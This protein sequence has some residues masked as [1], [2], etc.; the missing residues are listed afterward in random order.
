MIK[1]NGK[2]LVGK[3]GYALAPQKLVDEKQK[4]RFMYRENPDNRSDSGWRFFGGD[5]TD[6][7]VN[8]PDNI[9]PYDVNTIA[10]ID[11]DIIP[12]VDSPV[13]SAFERNDPKDPFKPSK[14]FNVACREFPHF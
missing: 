11:P 8:N 1:R 14:T 9:A 4:I 13:N 7:Y 10:E 12:F 2:R 5:E 6:E 3:M